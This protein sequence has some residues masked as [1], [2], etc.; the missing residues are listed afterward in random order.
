M[1]TYYFGVI[2]PKRLGHFL[3]PKEGNYISSQEE[4]S[5]PFSINILDAGL[6]PSDVPERQGDL[7]LSII[8]GW[9]VLGMWYRTG[10]K[11]GK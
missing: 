4:H 6:L 8:N 2:D 9:T 7:Y 3:Y 1:R 10:D 11:R 5:I